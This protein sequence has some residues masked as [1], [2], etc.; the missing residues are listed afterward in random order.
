MGPLNSRLTSSVD[1]GGTAGASGRDGGSEG[2]GLFSSPC[3]GSSCARF[4]VPN[5]HFNP[6]S[7]GSTTLTSVVVCGSSFS[8]VVLSTRDNR[9]W[10]RI[11]ERGCD[12][13]AS[14]GDT[15]IEN[16]MATRSSL[17]PPD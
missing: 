13:P 12:G 14:P 17:S 5:S 4:A 16:G 3:M 2:S 10:D 8:S 11:L 9:G 15:P 6:T 7:A 1:F